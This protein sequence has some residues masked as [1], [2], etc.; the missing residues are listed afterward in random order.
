MH[1]CMHMFVNYVSTWCMYIYVTDKCANQ[2]ADSF[3]GAVHWNRHAFKSPEYSI[4]LQL[5]W[6]FKLKLS[7]MKSHVFIIRTTVYNNMHYI[8][9]IHYKKGDKQIK[10]FKSQHLNRKS[11]LYIRFTYIVK[12]NVFQTG[13]WRR[14]LQLLQAFTN[15][16]NNN[17]IN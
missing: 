16:S 15:L 7:I 5:L 1:V 13:L 8:V 11:N 14:G 4:P 10:W 3:S 6:F 12:F 17:Y 2:S 9:H